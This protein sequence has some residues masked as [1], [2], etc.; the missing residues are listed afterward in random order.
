MLNDSQSKRAWQAPPPEKDGG[1][2]TPSTTGESSHGGLN[3]PRIELPQGGGALKG[4]DEKFQVNTASG[5]AQFSISLPLSPG[6]SGFVPTVGLGYD[7]GS[8]NS[9][10]G[11]GWSLSY[12]F[13]QRKT[14]KLLPTY[15]DVDESDVFLLSGA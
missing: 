3:I 14:D 2:E 5:T 11:L 15:Q 9:V 6:R 7:S 10:F 12:A 8:G 1:R 4:I 13:I